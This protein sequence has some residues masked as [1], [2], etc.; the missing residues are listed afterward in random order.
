MCKISLSETQ[1]L[2]L[3]GKICPYCKKPSEFIDSQVVYK[4]TSYGMIYYCASCEA[5]VGVHKD[6]DKALGRLANKEL[7]EWKS[8]AHFWF[9]KIWKEGYMSRSEAY[10][11]LSQK[12]NLP[13]EYTHIGMFGVET[14]QKV[15]QFS[16]DLLDVLK[17]RQVDV[18]IETLE[19][20]TQ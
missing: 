6:T 13:A 10:L 3:E 1:K 16:Q 17:G 12:S 19:L 9:D 2:M 4:W 7:R 18:L 8:N 11:W 20:K 15:V 14:C 5:Y